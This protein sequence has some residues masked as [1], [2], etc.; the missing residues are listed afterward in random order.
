MK[1]Y[2]EIVIDM[3]PE[4]DTFEQTLSEDSYEYSGEIHECKKVGKKIKRGLKKLG[5][6]IKKGVGKLWSGVKKGVS[7]IGDVWNHT[8]GKHGIAG[9][10]GKNTS[11]GR[12]IRA[13]LRKHLPSWIH[14]MRS[15]DWAGVL[16]SAVGPGAVFGKLGS[17]MNKAGGMWANWASKAP[18]WLGKGMMGLQKAVELPRTIFQPLLGMG[19][20]PNAMY[21]IGQGGLGFGTSG[22][23]K[24]ASNLGKIGMSMNNQV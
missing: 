3:N 11:L 21:S 20:N 13:G 4:S 12:K 1:I 22:Y 24:L 7:A 10:L 6:G 9:W 19:A 16:M 2:D 17:W 14:N 15:M 5:S 8:I 23:A 18:A